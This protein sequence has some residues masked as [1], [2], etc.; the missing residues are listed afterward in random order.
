MYTGSCRSV[1]LKKKNL[2]WNLPVGFHIYVKYLFGYWCFLRLKL[3]DDMWHRHP[4][5]AEQ[6]CFYIHSQSKINQFSKVTTTSGYLMDNLHYSL[7]LIQKKNKRIPH[8]EPFKSSKIPNFANFVRLYW[9]KT[10]SAFFHNF[11]I[12]DFRSSFREFVF[13]VCIVYN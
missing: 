4:G 3:K 6:W 10:Q 1:P 11:G 12:Y 8:K 7:L 5:H 13:F 9:Y 2:I